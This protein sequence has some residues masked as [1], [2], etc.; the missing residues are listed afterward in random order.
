[1][2]LVFLIS[3]DHS[4]MCKKS[5]IVRTPWCENWDK[6][7]DELKAG[8]KRCCWSKKKIFH[9]YD[10]QCMFRTLCSLLTKQLLE[11]VKNIMGNKGIKE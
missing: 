6:R 3:Y 1:M 8:S 11:S 7:I 9:L 5:E 4:V 2:R 10:G